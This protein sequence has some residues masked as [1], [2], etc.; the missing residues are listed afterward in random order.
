MD[1]KGCFSRAGT[2]VQF[3][4][5]EAVKAAGPFDTVLGPG[6]GLPYGCG[7]DTDYLLRVREA[8]FPVRRVSSVHVFHPEPADSYPSPE[9]VNAY[10]A[11]RMYLLKKHAFPLWFRLANILYPLLR[12]PFDG[13]RHGI[14]AVKYRWRMF[15]GRLRNF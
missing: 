5:S 8:G 12:L 3:F 10:A 4:R 7:E 6:N 14:E 1:E 15:I 9:K 11:G 2:C 13:A